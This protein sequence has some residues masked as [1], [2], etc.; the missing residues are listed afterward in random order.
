MCQT[1]FH[2]CWWLLRYGTVKIAKNWKS[3]KQCK[4]VPFLI[5]DIPVQCDCSLFHGNILVI[6]TPCT[7]TINHC[8]YLHITG[9]TRFVSMTN[10]ILLFQTESQKASLQH[11][12][13]ISMLYNITW[14]CT[15]VIGHA[16]RLCN[17]GMA[18]NFRGRKLSRIG[19]KYDFC[20]ENFHRLLACAVLKDPTPPNF[21]EK[22]SWIATKPQNLRKFFP[23]KVSHYTVLCVRR[24]QMLLW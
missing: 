9:H 21:T 11:R 23:S 1:S 16:L 5:Y 2:S 18:G 10:L 4:V 17:E 19:K 22:I 13:V 7:C 3:V 14:Y 20:G 8:L 12:L 24:D 15:C 6:H